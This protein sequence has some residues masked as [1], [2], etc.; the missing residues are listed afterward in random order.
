MSTGPG[1]RTQHVAIVVAGFGQNAILTTVT[2]FILLY[3]SQY[4]RLSTAGIAVAGTVITVVKVLD[5]VSDPVVGSVID[6][7]RTR[8]GKLRPFI[9]GAAAP[10]ALLTGLLFAVPDAAEPTQ[11]VYFTIVYVLWGIA[12]TM[13][14][15]PLWGLIGSAFAEPAQRT[16]VISNVRVF[17]SISL[18]LATLGMPW[19]AQALSSG[20]RTTGTGWSIAV[21]ATA[22]AGMGLYTLAGVFGRERR[23]T[24]TTRLRF[25]ELFGT[26]FRNRPLLLVLLGSVLGFGRYIVQAGGSVFVLIAYGKDS[27]GLFTVV[28]AAIIA[29][30]VIASFLTPFLLRRL[31]AR[32][33]IVGS[34][35]VGALLYLVLWFVGFE[36]LV[37]L[38]VF[39]FLTG[40]SLGVFGVV[41]TTMIADAVDDAE[42][43]TGR[44]NDGISFATLTFS[45][46][47]MNALSVFAFSVFLVLAG[48]QAG[49]HVTATMQSTVFA[50]ITLVPAAS[51]VLSA[52]PFLFYRI[53]GPADEAGHR[54]DTDG[55]KDAVDPSGLR[56]EGDQ[57]KRTPA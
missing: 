14:D 19:L 26:L 55:P 8:L 17:G 2:T 52:V 44:R 7:T 32:A 25:R 47:I 57:G 49:V 40:L 5:A 3:L 35:L 13:C 6:M 34:S 24:A 16:R 10:V 9:L 54:V 39:I 38:L 50:A 21:F 4:A 36:D 46:K 28:G 53:G 56:P 45:S 15:V 31:S 23:T 51:C 41:Q 27:E 48:Y 33:L 18:G 1:A 22:I 30:L 43:R 12:Y 20:P 42:R 37:A 11:L 29:G